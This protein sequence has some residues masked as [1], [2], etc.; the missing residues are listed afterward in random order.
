MC[1]FYYITFCEMRNMKRKRFLGLI[2]VLVVMMTVCVSCLAG[3]GIRKPI[4]GILK[5][6]NH[7]S[8]NNCYEGIIQGLKEG[9]RDEFDDYDVEMLDSNFD[10]SVGIAN[11]NALATRVPVIVGA[12][13][14]PSAMAATITSNG[15][16][17][18]V[19]SAVSDPYSEDV[20]LDQYDYV[21][22][23]RDLL[24]F[25]GQ[26]DVIEHFIP[27]VKKIGVLRCTQE[28]NSASQLEVLTEK[29]ELRGIT[30]ECVTVGY[31]N[32]IPMAI[33]TL[34]SRGVDCITNLNDNTIV[35][36]LDMLIEKANAKNIPVFGSEIEQVK[37]GCLASASLDYVE[38]GRITGLMMSDI[39]LGNKKTSDI[40]FKV[41]DDSFNC[42]NSSQYERFGMTA[43]LVGYEKVV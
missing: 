9:L 39:I 40:D 25:D 42:Y 16:F 23:T 20:A 13:A 24:D 38:L 29:A 35:G 32:E 27:T 10:S 2:A 17:P 11:A 18:V 37:N 6:G 33:D 30:V 7:E 43:D 3:C 14:T 34:L 22:G 28:Q 4:I 36:A 19:F 12:I 15:R 1:I 26:L 31:T 41:I 8:L 21:T 5:F